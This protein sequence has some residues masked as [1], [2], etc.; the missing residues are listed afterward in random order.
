MRASSVGINAICVHIPDHAFIGSDQ[1][2]F[3]AF[4]DMWLMMN[5]QK[6]DVQLV[7]LFAL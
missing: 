3:L 7:T 4:E 5:L 1:K 2:A 6:L